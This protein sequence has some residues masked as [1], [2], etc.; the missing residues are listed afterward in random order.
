MNGNV[1]EW[2]YDWYAGDIYKTRAGQVTKDPRGAEQGSYRVMRGG[3]WGNLRSV[4]RCAYRNRAGP[5][6]FGSY[7]GFRLVRSPSSILPEMQSSGELLCRGVW[8][9]AG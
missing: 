6:Y 1:Y 5:G 4:A 7:I 2:C 3:S 9:M 8:T